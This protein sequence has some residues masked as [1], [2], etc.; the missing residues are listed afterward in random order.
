MIVEDH[1]Q[2]RELLEELVEA[3]DNL[4]VAGMASNGADGYEQIRKLNPDVVLLDLIMPGMDGLGVLEKLSN[5]ETSE[6]RPKVIVV[7][8]VSEERIITEAFRLGASY[9]VVKPFD[10]EM[11]ISRIKVVMEAERYPGCKMKWILPYED[12]KALGNREVKIEITEILH[13]LG[14]PAHMKGYRYLKEAIRLVIESESIL[15]S[16]TGRLYPSIA[17]AFHTTSGRV[18]RA[19]RRAIES[20]WDRGDCRV[21][22][23]V[24]GYTVHKE[25]G[26]PTNSEFIALIA[27]WLKVGS[28]R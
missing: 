6:K 17:A 15:E 24:F 14:I 16:V 22:E 26:R 23:A 27:D 19:I 28:G 9:Y 4:V 13:R 11:L 5:E 25:K 21:Q 20:A 3:D 10:R 7:S 2:M 1:M 18:E 8:A 12:L